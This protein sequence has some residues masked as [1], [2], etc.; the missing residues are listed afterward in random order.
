MWR[1]S[2]RFVGL[3]GSSGAE[4]G[5]VSDPPGTGAASVETASD[6]RRK[7]ELEETRIVQ[8]TRRVDMYR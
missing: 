5:L 7:D 2:P 8:R 1:V 4:C 6:A 3:P